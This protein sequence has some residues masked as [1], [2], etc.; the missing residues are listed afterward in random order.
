MQ[1]HFWFMSNFEH[2]KFAINGK[3]FQE[4]LWQSKLLCFTC[5]LSNIQKCNFKECPLIWVAPLTVFLPFWNKK[6]I[7]FMVNVLTR[8]C[9]W[10]MLMCDGEKKLTRFVVYVCFLWLICRFWMEFWKRSKIGL[11]SWV[12]H[13]LTLTTCWMVVHV[14]C[15]GVLCIMEMWESC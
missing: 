7:S 2:V 10:R 12:L 9:K 5:D 14:C 15:Y 3:I 6:I 8:K 11:L 13:K 4:K 1:K